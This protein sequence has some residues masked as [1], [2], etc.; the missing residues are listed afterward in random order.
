M[1]PVALFTACVLIWGTT[2][3]A[4]TFQL[5]G[6]TPEVGVAIRFSL[7]A[8]LLLAWCRWR[9]ISLT[10]PL[11]EHAWIALL[12]G[13]NFTATYLLVYH[14]E[15]LIVSGLVAVGYSAMPLVNMAL[16]RLIFGTPMSRRVALAGLC[17]VVGIVLVFW[18]EFERAQFA[19]RADAALVLGAVLT[20]SAVLLSAF[21]NMVVHR[22]H[23]AGVEGWAPLALGM[24]YG[25]IVTW[26]VVAVRGDPVIIAWSPAFVL[27]LLY[28]SIFGSA[29]AFGA[30]FTLLARIGAARAAYIG[31]MVT[32]V[33]LIVSA[34][35]EG[36][37]WRWI[38]V[39]GI[40]L[41]VFGNVLALRSA[42]S[43]ARPVAEPGT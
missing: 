11:R 14:A 29:L 41:A 21:G 16:A 34:L 2:W 42:G 5:D 19:A 9:R 28:L 27:S 6:A 43:A 23:E 32:I 3:Y 31:V 24:G 25:A 18:P 22:N 12:G 1:N 17:G 15:R 20:A 10:F 38:T 33:A 4:I 26:I 7:A 30:Y 36:Y 39:L 8:A 35:F 40:A 37:D 13:L